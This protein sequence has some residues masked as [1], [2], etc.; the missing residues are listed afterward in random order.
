[1][2][3]GYAHGGS[4]TPVPRVPRLGL[5]A[6][7]RATREARMSS[8]RARRRLAQ[9]LER[10]VAR[11]EEP[12]APFTAVIPV[13]REAVHLAHGA[14]LDLAE[15]LRAPRPVDPAGV[16]LARALLFDGAG[17]LYVPT[18]SGELRAAAIRALEALDGHVDV[19]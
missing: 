6:R 7:W 15:R 5:R 12:H 17:P 8:E 3:M 19:R 13:H 4:A 18:C 16:R 2:R 9:D 14:L 10:A 11:A 1:M